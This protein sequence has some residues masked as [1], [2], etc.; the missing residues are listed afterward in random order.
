MCNNH[1]IKNTRG[2]DG[3]DWNGLGWIRLERM[4]ACRHDLGTL[5]KISIVLI[6]SGS[7]I[8]G[9]STRMDDAQHLLKYARKFGKKAALRSSFEY[10]QVLRD[11]R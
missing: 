3:L 11:N 7:R 1:R 10:R 8:F 2:I 6:N 5:I 9:I 4:V